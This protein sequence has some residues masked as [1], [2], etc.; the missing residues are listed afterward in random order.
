M[1][2]LLAVSGL[3]LGILQYQPN[4]GDYIPVWFSTP[5]VPQLGYQVY[6]SN[7]TNDA[8]KE[9]LKDVR[10]SLRSTYKTGKDPLPDTYLLSQTDYLGCWGNKPV[11]TTGRSEAWESLMTPS[12]S[13]LDASDELAPRELHG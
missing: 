4:A 13:A 12:D 2:L 10:R 7:F 9:L 1:S 8:V 11:R 5:I 3:T 6:F